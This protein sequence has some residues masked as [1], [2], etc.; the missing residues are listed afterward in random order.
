SGEPADV[1]MA[2]VPALYR[3]VD[4]MVAARQTHSD[5]ELHDKGKI[6]ELTRTQLLEK[7]QEFA[8]AAKRAIAEQLGHEA[9]KASSVL[10]PWLR[11]EQA[12]LDVQLSQNYPR[13]EEFCWQLLGE[14]PVKPKEIDESAAMEMTPEALSAAI[15]SEAFAAMLRNRAFTTVMNLA[16]RR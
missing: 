5:K 9:K 8:T 12:Y 14:V 16:A 13:V 3:L 1:L 7:K 6:D 2:E 4:A 15:R 10:S 11:M